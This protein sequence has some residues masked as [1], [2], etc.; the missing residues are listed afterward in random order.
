MVDIVIPIFLEGSQWENNE[1]RYALRS[2]E[3]NMKFNFKVVI[4]SRGVPGWMSNVKKIT[5]ERYFPNNKISYK[6]YE[7]FF[8]T[9]NKLDYVSQQENISEKFIYAYDDVILMKQIGESF[10]ERNIAMYSISEFKDS[11]RWGQTIFK[12]EKLVDKTPFYSYEHHI[13]VMFEKSKLRRMFEENN[14]RAMKIPYAP[15]SVYFNN[16]FE[17][18]DILLKDH[19]DIV[20][21]NEIN[22]E[23]I[24]L[25]Y[26]DSGLPKVKEWIVENFKEPSKYEKC[27]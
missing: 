21:Y 7:M 9:L 13:P 10:F 8:D 6:A 19:N 5:M 2:F 18:P 12:A 20:C 11:G 27:Q 15:I 25:N 3:K 4:V 23:R 22:E 14:F 26:S 24:W 1:L 17:H 16:Y